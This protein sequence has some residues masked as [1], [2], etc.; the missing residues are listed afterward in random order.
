MGDFNGDGYPDLGRVTPHGEFLLIPGKAGGG[1]GP[2][3]RIGGG[4][5]ALTL[6][7]GGIDFDGDRNPDVIGRTSEGNLVLYRGDGRGGW[8]G[9]PIQIGHGWGGFTLAFNAGDF[10][11]DGYADL[12]ARSN[13]GGLWIYPTGGNNRWKSAHRV[14]TGWGGFTSILSPGDF[15]G[16]G[17][18]DVLARATNGDLYLYRGNGRGGWGESSIV[19]RGWSGFTGLG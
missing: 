3:V 14:G 19:G 11:G 4:W 12:I 7:T 10:D 16:D 2:Q 1:Y 9:G 5:S 8:A 17:K 13:D 6:L 15:T 18:T